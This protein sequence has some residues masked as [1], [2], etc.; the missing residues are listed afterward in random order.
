MFFNYGGGLHSYD[1][2]PSGHTTMAMAPTFFIAQRYGWLKAIPAIAI[3]SFVAYSRI[4]VKAHWVTDVLV[5][6]G[7]SFVYAYLLT[8]KKK[9]SDQLRYQHLLVQLVLSLELE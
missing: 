5:A 9:K 3:S 4:A 6:T 7:V 2:F 1:S 8:F